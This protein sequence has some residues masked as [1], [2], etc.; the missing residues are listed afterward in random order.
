MNHHFLEETIYLKDN[1]QLMIEEFKPKV[2][3]SNE[4]LLR[5]M[6]LLEKLNTAMS[7][8]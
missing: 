2:D 4:N 8:H 3:H 1:N 7:K 5:L 6:F